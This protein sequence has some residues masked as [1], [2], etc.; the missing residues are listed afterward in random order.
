MKLTNLNVSHFG[1]LGDN[2]LDKMHHEGI[3]KIAN[4]A[5]K[6]GRKW[7]LPAPG[8]TTTPPWAAT[9]RKRRLLRGGAEGCKRG[10]QQ[11]PLIISRIGGGIKDLKKSIFSKSAFPSTRS[12]DNSSV[13]GD[14]SDTPTARGWSR[15]VWQGLPTKSSKNFPHQRQKWRFEK[16]DFP[17][18]SLHFVPQL[19]GKSGERAD[20]NGAIGFV[21]G[22]ETEEAEQFRVQ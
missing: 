22:S 1:I 19:C 3:S 13:S 8:R 16:V 5:F 10:F 4:L 21:I 17:I 15:K 20:H 11:C 12:Y 2:P 18:I 14:I 9:S 7:Q 6:I